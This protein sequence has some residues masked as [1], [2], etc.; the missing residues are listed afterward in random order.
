LRLQRGDFGW[1]DLRRATFVDAAGLRLLDSLELA[2]AVSIRKSVSPDY[3]ICLDDGKRFKALRRHLSTLGMTPEQYRAKWNLP[4]DY[5]MVAANY[6]AQRSAL[7]KKIGLGQLRKKTV[8]APL[9]PASVSKRKAARPR[10]A[11]AKAK[12]PIAVV[13]KRSAIVDKSHSEPS[14]TVRSGSTP[15]VRGSPVIGCHERLLRGENGHSAEGLSRYVVVN[16]K[17][18]LDSADAPQEVIDFF[19]RNPQGLPLRF[20]REPRLFERWRS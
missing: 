6:A 1:L 11:K 3:L 20:L 16:A 12:A 9:P 2:L 13:S 14:P 17:V 7:A 4:A 5:P 15:V 8:P 18:F 19:P 10:K